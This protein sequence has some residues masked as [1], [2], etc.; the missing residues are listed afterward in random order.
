MAKRDKL[1]FGKCKV[2]GLHKVLTE[3]HIPP[4]STFNNGTIKII[5][6]DEAMKTITDKNRLPWDFDGLKYKLK[7]GGR[8][9]KTLCSTC[10][11]YFGTNYVNHYQINANSL[12]YSLS[13]ITMDKCESINVRSENFRPL[14][15][16][17]QV[18][19][20]FASITNIAD[21][22]NVKDFLL[23]KDNNN[24]DK[25]KL[26]IYMSIFKDGLN[27][28][29]G[30]SALYCKNGTYLVSE[31]V[32]YPF[33]FVLLGNA[34]EHTEQDCKHLGVDITS[35]LDFKYEDE[36]SIEIS[37]P[38]HECNINLPCDYRSKKEILKCTQKKSNNKQIDG[39]E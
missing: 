10:N 25:S 21:D 17:K 15:F 23:N 7:Q 1:E 9:F 38:L 36:T 22:V 29:F 18:I 31:I 2:C 5:N 4:K 14:P 26:R 6:A 11:S 27:R 16:I 3:E 13:Q 33:I 34:D 20:M 24:F 28:L 37:L 32:S 35:F 30:W 8:T 12:A 19:A 39:K